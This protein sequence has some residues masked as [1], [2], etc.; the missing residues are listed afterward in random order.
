MAGLCNCRVKVR[1]PAS[2]EALFWSSFKSIFSNTDTAHD[3]G[4][5]SQQRSGAKTS[6]DVCLKEITHQDKLLTLSMFKPNIK[7]Q[8]E[9]PVSAQSFF[10]IKVY[11]QGGDVD[12][13]VVC[14]PTV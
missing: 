14:P 3:N 13:L 2:R 12:E 4:Q 8:R 7:S 10:W 1:N 9:P 6:L 5:R 11:L